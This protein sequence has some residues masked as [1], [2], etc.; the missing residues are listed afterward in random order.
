MVDAVKGG[1]FGDPVDMIGKRITAESSQVAL[2]PQGASW[3]YELPTGASTA[4]LEVRNAAGQTV[5]SGPADLARGR[6][7]FTWDG[8]KTSGSAAAEGLYTLTVKAEDSAG[9]AMAGRTYVEGVVTGVETLNGSAVLW[10]G[11]TQVP[12][13]RVSAVRAAG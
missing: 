12:L 13:D 4:T 2:T 7:E 3:S 9:Y 11:K 1:D 6:Q 8:K 5:W 10:L